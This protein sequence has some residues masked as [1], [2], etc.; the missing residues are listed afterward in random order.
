MHYQEIELPTPLNSRLREQLGNQFN[1]FTK[2]LKSAAPTSIRTNPAKPTDQFAGC[3]QI[4]WCAQGGYLTQRPRFTSDPLF[5][6]GS[7][8]VQEA[9][10]MFL[11]HVVSQALDLDKDYRVLDISAAPGGKA[12]LLQS[13]F[14]PDSLLVANEVI[15]S[16]NSILRH[17]MARW[18]GDNYVITQSDPK[19]FKKLPDFF[20]VIVVDAPCSGEGLIRKDPASVQEWSE[21]NVMLC[22]A[23]Q[24]RILSD[25]LPSLKPGGILIYSTCTFSTAENEEN[26]Q[27]LSQE[28]S[29]TPLTIEFPETWGIHCE[30]VLNPGYR[31]YPHRVR[32]EGFF[33]AAFLKSGTAGGSVRKKKKFRPPARSSEDATLDDSL[34]L[35]NPERY[36]F[37]TREKYRIA[38]PKVIYSDYLT[39]SRALRITSSGLNM[40]KVYHARL[41]PSAEL[42]LSQHLSSGCARIELSLE[43]GLDYLSHNSLRLDKSIRE[44]F[45]LVCYQGHGLGWIHVL[46]NGQIRNKYPQT[47][48]ILQRYGRPET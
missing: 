45:V 30:D 4:P 41:K 6:A 13:L 3:D 44:G 29:L 21:N 9:S 26:V 16:R 42:A 43:Q 32:G 23:R 34:W 10:S 12:T 25:V 27:W 36:F 15:G 7:Y 18:G 48:R 39:L 19:Y 22:A 38:M 1:S 24:K 14:S 28:K 33:I 5:H 35:D 47:W 17:N 20:D 40:G 46:N 2:A 8:Y 11:S 31:F 37:L